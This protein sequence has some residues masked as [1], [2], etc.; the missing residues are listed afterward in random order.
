MNDER[1]DLWL[2]DALEPGERVAFEADL[3]RDAE[4]RARVEEARAALALVHEWLDEQPPGV[5][6][7]A[8]LAIP[9]PVVALP[10]PRIARWMQVAAAIALLAVGFALG[11]L[12]PTQPSAEPVPSPFAEEQPAGRDTPR[13]APARDGDALATATPRRTYDDQGRLVIET[14]HATWIVDATLDLSTPTP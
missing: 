2:A 4:L 12:S 9:A 8:A 10:A 11:R 3:A 13:S 6:R 1:I 14:A 7:V 5:E